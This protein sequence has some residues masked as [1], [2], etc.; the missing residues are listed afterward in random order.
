MRMEDEEFSPYGGFGSGC[1]VHG[2]DYLRECTMCGIEFCSACFPNSTLC[3]DCAAQG[4][5]DGDLEEESQTDEEKEL[6]LIEGFDEEGGEAESGE[7]PPPIPAGKMA[8]KPAA[9]AGAKPAAA[10]P[11]KPA[12][13]PAAKPAGKAQAAPKA[14]GKPAAKAK[15]KAKAQVK[16]KPKVKA[17]PK[18]KA[19][20]A[21]K[22][23][24]RKPA[25]AK[26]RPRKKR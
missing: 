4:E 10:P 6:L 25:Q 22:A 9:K 11:A 16:T 14:K 12:P 23:K 3:P 5:I 15:P 26:S 17:R 13:K 1:E 8:V 20:A 7:K 2:E 19:K 21:A 18:P 24:A